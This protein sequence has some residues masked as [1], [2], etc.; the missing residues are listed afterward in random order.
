M[1]KRIWM[2]L[3]VLPMLL[4]ALCLRVEAQSKSDLERVYQNLNRYFYT[5]FYSDSQYFEAYSAELEKCGELLAKEN[6]TDAEINRQ[7]SNIQKAYATLVRDSFDYSSLDRMVQ[8]YESLDLNLFEEESWR[9]LS[10]VMEDIYKEINGP[11]LFEKGNKSKAAFAEHIA[12]HLSGY[13]RRFETAYNNLVLT[14]LPIPLTTSHLD[15]LVHYCDI[16]ARESVMSKSVFWPAY[17]DAKK[18][19]ED[20]IAA[21]RP[22]QDTIDACASELLE[23]Y[24]RLEKDS[25]DFGPIDAELARFRSSSKYDYTQSSWS[26][27]EKAVANLQA[28]RNLTYFF[29]L[30][31]EGNSK[32]SL[33]AIQSYFNAMTSEASEAYYSLV[34]QES[35]NRLA[36]LCNTYRNASAGEGLKNPVEKLHNSVVHGLE[37][38][39]DADA[40][41]EEVDLVITEI[42]EMAK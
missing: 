18:A 10:D 28:K 34:S 9:R 29:Y 3:L 1:K 33:N 23:A 41:Q 16:S 7:Y 30:A 40:T 27:Y 42:E 14:T 36:A 4:G 21:R 39:S 22:K 6:P 13:E 20:C 8:D 38:L 2:I 11:T 15:A 12:T 25:L 17:Q 19:A 26:R 31:E 5:P 35:V 24:A 32:E 37:V